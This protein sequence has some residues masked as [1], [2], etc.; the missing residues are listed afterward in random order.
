M[1]HRPVNLG[2][3]QKKHE[4]ENLSNFLV[5]GS[6]VLGGALQ[7]DEAEILRRKKEQQRKE[8]TEA[9]QQQIEEKKA[10]KLANE[11]RENS[12]PYAA[13]PIR[14]SDYP[15]DATPAIA[16]MVPQSSELAKRTPQTSAP[17]R[18]LPQASEPV[19]L[20]NLEE[21]RQIDKTVEAP[22]LLLQTQPTPPSRDD[23]AL[24]YLSQLC[25]K[26]I[27][28]QQE[29]KSKVLMQDSVIEK[30]TQ[31]P[32]PGH[33][34]ETSTSKADTSSS[35][36]QLPPRRASAQRLKQKEELARISEIEQKIEAAR[37]RAEERK[38]TKSKADKR[39]TMSRIDHQTPQRA[40]TS[41]SA[42][43]TSSTNPRTTSSSNARTPSVP[44]RLQSA[45]PKL[46]TEVELPPLLSAK[47]IE[48]MQIATSPFKASDE[49][50]G[51]SHFIYP[52]SEGQFDD[53]LDKFMQTQGVLRPSMFQPKFP[54]DLFTGKRGVEYTPSE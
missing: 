19:L 41:T 5:N 18:A 7:R 15:T 22:N 11:R 3:F 35:K 49:F 46:S 25:Q 32:T 9:L 10:L 1:E 38:H 24:D 16:M 4:I 20:F 50:I 43:A 37:K 52:N 8:M 26:L 36:R 42:R 21:A 6:H 51:S 48:T 30:L 27:Q 17:G 28:E 39:A 2:R 53:E 23:D 31:P 33:K 54:R 29:L 45:L 12:T 47:S 13:A 34:S 40:P 44:L 14:Q